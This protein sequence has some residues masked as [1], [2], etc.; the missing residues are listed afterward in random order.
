M[1]EEQPWPGTVAFL[2]GI[3]WWEP[4]A[5]AGV[6]P[7]VVADI[8]AAARER[9]GRT[10]RTAAV[11]RERVVVARPEALAAAGAAIDGWETIALPVDEPPHPIGDLFLA[12]AAVERRRSHLE[13]EVGRAYRA[14]SDG[15]LVVDGSLTESPDWAG[16]RRMVGVIKSHASLPFAGE[17]LEAYLRLPHRTRSSV[18]QPASRARAPVHSWALRLWPWEG[19]D[20][21]YGLVRVEVAPTDD[22]TGRADEISRWLLAERAPVSTPDARWD[23]L[24]YGIHD[25]ERFLRSER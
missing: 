8:A 18:F 17:A 14:G 1:G 16:D 13:R 25:V 10:F 9:A 2:D 6:S 5:S 19:K 20:L 7:V 23:R 22:P 21:L 24:L 3:Q 4:V 11:R 15:W 12:R